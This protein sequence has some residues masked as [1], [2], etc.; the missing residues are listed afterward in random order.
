MRRKIRKMSSRSSKGIAVYNDNIKDANVKCS[1]CGKRVF[2][3]MKRHKSHCS[4]GSENEQS[5]EPNKCPLCRKTYNDFSFFLNDLYSH[6]VDVLVEDSDNLSQNVCK[7]CKYNSDAAAQ[8]ID[9]VLKHVNS[10]VLKENT[11]SNTLK[12]IKKEMTEHEVCKPT[13]KICGKTISRKYAMKRH[14]ATHTG[15]KKF[16]CHHCGKQYAQES[17]LQRHMLVIHEG[18]RKYKCP[19]CSLIFGSNS[20]LKSHQDTHTDPRPFQCDQCGKTFISQKHLYH[21]RKYH[22]TANGMRQLCKLCNRYFSSPSV[23]KR[24]HKVVHLRLKEFQCHICSAQ[25]ST[26][27]YLQEHLKLH[28][29]ERPEVC[30]FCGKTFQMSGNLRQH[31]K[32]H[33]GKTQICYICGKGFTRRCHLLIHM[34]SHRGVEHPQCDYCSQVFLLKSD[35]E[36]HLKKEHSEENVE[37]KSCLH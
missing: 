8:L 15:E 10:I 30:S 26:K 6:L 11:E 4:N 23:L 24:H 37:V 21:H 19:I 29:D 18:V 17:G 28:S 35:L 3:S 31:M 20:D 33:M 22:H 34:G 5:F 14:M 27:H 12:R 16:T 7:V 9:H 13:C 1:K 32:T 2:H 25:L 36:K